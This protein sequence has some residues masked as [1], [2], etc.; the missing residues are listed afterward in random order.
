MPKHSLPRHFAEFHHRNPKGLKFYGIDLI[1][2]HWRGENK[3]IKVSR[4]ETKWIY[5][6]DSLQPRG[7]NLDIDLN[8]LI[9]NFWSLLLIY[10][11]P[12]RHTKH[13]QLHFI[14]NLPWYILSTPPW[15]FLYWVTIIPQALPLRRYIAFIPFFKVLK[16]VESPLS[17]SVYIYYLS[18]NIRIASNQG[19]VD[20][21]HPL[22][23]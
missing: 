11:S 16:Y 17:W 8:C 22:F 10:T 20:I 19:P 7:I 23:L 9:S 6:L 14:H 5:L 1:K 2:G 13:I 4:N 21:H 12:P 18:S 15:T 3:R